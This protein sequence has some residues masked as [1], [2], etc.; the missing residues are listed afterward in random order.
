MKITKIEFENLNSLKGHW[1]IDLT[2]EAFK[3]NHNQFVICGETGAGKTTI[4]DAITLALYGKTARLNRIDG[5][6]NEIMTRNTNSCMA[7]VTYECEGKTYVSKFSQSRRPR[8]G[9]LDSTDFSILNT[10]TGELFSAR[11]SSEME[12]R[13]AQNIQLDYGQFCRSIMLAQGEFSV[14]L[15]GEKNSSNNERKRAEILAKINGTEKYKK[16]GERICKKAGE[17]ENEYRL[18]KSDLSNIDFLDDRDIEK[19]ESEKKSSEDGAKKIDAEIATISTQINWLNEIREN[20][21]KLEQAKIGRKKFEERKQIFAHSQT[22]LDKAEKAKNCD[23]EYSRFSETKKLIEN[24]NKKLE[25]SKKALSLAEKEFVSTQSDAEIAKKIYEKENGLS[26]EKEELWKKV[27][28]LDTKIGPSKKMFCD[29]SERKNAAEKEWKDAEQKTA[30]LEKQKSIYEEE[31]DGLQKYL[32]QNK[33]DENLS[34]KIVFLNGLAKSIKSNETEK[35]N[36]EK[37]LDAQ[38]KSLEQSKHKLE[39]SEKKI[40]EIETQLETLVSREY[41]NISALIRK[42]LSSGNPCPVCGSKEHPYCDEKS[43]DAEKNFS[44]DKIMLAENVS[45]LHKKY[46]AE[47]SEGQNL[48]ETASRLETSILG[49]QERIKSLADEKNKSVA[50]INAEIAGWNFSFDADDGVEKIVSIVSEL[51]KRFQKFAEQKSRLEQA[52]TEA[53]NIEIEL[54]SIDLGSLKNIFE[55]E[56]KKF[57]EIKTNFESLVEERKNLFGEKSVDDEERNFKIN[58]QNLLKNLE[59]ADEKKDAAIKNKIVME[60][61]LENYRKQIEEKNPELEAHGEELNIALEKNGFKSVDEYLLC[62]ASDEKIMELENE[63]QNLEKEDASTL[64]SVKLASENL[65]KCR[66]K[67]LSQKNADE[68]EKEFSEKSAE[69]DGANKRIGEI[70]SILKNQ[71]ENKARYNKKLE[72][73]SELE[74]KHTLWQEMKSLIGVNDGSDFEVFVQSMALQNLLIKANRYIHGITGRFSLVQKGQGVDFMVHDDNYPDPN[75][76]RPI[77]NMSGG[78][79]FIISLSLALGIAEL[80]SR[81]VQVN[82][83]FLDEGFGTLSGTPLIEAV[84]SLKSLESTGKTLG[85]IT[86]VSDVIKEFDQKIVAEKHGGTS[87]LKGDGVVRL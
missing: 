20:S 61:E 54:K 55:N 37:N 48:K 7:S 83:L 9:K 10:E 32:D 49:F 75:D 26:K 6:N 12:S 79:K 28:E 47:K 87:I 21:L 73:F 62:R 78:E 22:V 23:I 65:E 84:N 27:R 4:L 18:A 11:K 39:E 44:S 64:A 58:L 70:N 56:R 35:S 69:R 86:H 68:L 40:H 25:A 60:S 42:N 74:K 82:S 17:I 5:N 19:L 59:G 71:S 43:I 1:L 13:T 80:A 45:Q 33:K 67:N 50:E 31:I 57:E 3:K 2:H 66:A 77:V 51:K 30:N 36:I 14:F 16:I 76:D 81:N 15:E 41:L 53:G 72:A 52:K 46:E 34:E 38:N 24:L 63:K 8:S 29:Q 85:I